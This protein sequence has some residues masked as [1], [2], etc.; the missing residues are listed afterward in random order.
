MIGISIIIA[1]LIID[2]G[3]VEIANALKDIAR[4]LN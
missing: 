4:R 3:L 1:A 2:R